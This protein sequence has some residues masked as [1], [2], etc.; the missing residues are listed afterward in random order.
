MISD[1]KEVGKERPFG[2]EE[3]SHTEVR[4]NIR[5]FEKLE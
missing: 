3:S 5:L 1:E 4:E 2:A